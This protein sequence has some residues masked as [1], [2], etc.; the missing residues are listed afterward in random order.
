MPDLTPF[1]TRCIGLPA[2]TREVK[3]IKT[4]PRINIRPE[5]SD[6]VYSNLALVSF[7]RAEFVL[8]FARQ[9]PGLPT[10]NLKARVILSP[11]RVK[12]LI[13]ALDNQVKAYE[14]RFG[15][16]EEGDPQ[17]PIGFQNPQGQT[18]EGQ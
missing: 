2:D 16:L 10:A 9:M 12:S 7:S 6:G 18:Q 4:P 11:H 1:R 13:A 5:D 17:A 8:D 14:G 3:M 15:K